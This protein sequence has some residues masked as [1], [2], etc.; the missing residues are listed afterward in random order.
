[1]IS[2]SVFDIP[3]PFDR[4][5]LRKVAEIQFFICFCPKWAIIF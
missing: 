4:L 3:L 2:E 1:M 5:V